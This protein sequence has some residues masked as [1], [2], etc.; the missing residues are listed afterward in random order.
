M[1]GVKAV[2]ALPP[3]PSASPAPT[4]F[5]TD[6]QALRAI[7]VLLV[8][9][10][11]VWPATV[12]G[13]Y[14]GVDVFFVIS[15]YLIT[16]HLV[17]EVAATGRLD[18]PAF[19]ARR[20]RRLLPAASL[21]LVAVGLATYMWVPPATWPI[22][23][24][25]MVASTLYAENWALVRRAVDYLA[26]D[27]TPSPLQH[28]WSLAVEEQFYVG[29][30]LLVAG[31]AAAW[32]RRAGAMADPLFGLAPPPPPL[33][34]FALP[35]GVLCGL[36]FV[37]AQ[38]YAHANPAA[39]YF[40][41]HT[42][43]HELG[44]GGLLGV[45]AAARAPAGPH[46]NAKLGKPTARPAS[47]WRRTFAAA[48]GL[49]AVGASGCLYTAATP[50]PGTAALVPVLGAAAVIAAGEG[51]V[52]N[53]SPAHALA[54]ALAHPWLQYV[55][56]ISYSLYL[57][58][59]PVVVMYPFITGRAV[60]GVFADGVTVLAL[61]WAMAHACKRGWED[62]FRG[63]GG[64]GGGGGGACK[65]LARTG[66]LRGAISMTVGMAL[67]V[68]A[69]S[70]GLRGR[71]MQ[72]LEAPPGVDAALSLTET[73]PSMPPDSSSAP[74]PRT[75]DVTRLQGDA[76]DACSF[77]MGSRDNSDPSMHFPGADIAV[78]GCPLTNSLPISKARPPVGVASED[79]PWVFKKSSC[80]IRHQEDAELTPCQAEQPADASTPSRR[81]HVVLI[82]DSHAAHWVPAFEA[83]S[84]RMGFRF[85]SLV[86]AGC[87]PSAGL[88]AGKSA[89]NLVCQEWVGKAV[90]WV[91]RERPSAVVLSSH[92]YRPASTDP[93]NAAE[94]AEGVVRIARQ[95]VAAEIP[96]LG[97]KATPSMKASVPQC[98]AMA[99]ARDPGTRDVAAC[100]M[101]Q[102]A[103]LPHPN[104]PV[105]A[106]AEM[107]PIMRLLSFD[108][109][110]CDDQ[111]C[112]AMMGNVIVYR[113]R[114][115]LT[116]TFSA[117]LATALQK[118]LEAAA[119]HLAE[120]RP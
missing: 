89:P 83:A 19:Y 45:W 87:P 13:G 61:S 98:L 74:I 62:R 96:V 102:A 26:Q 37:T 55:G 71:A 80:A 94:L 34:A 111:T 110:L 81:P 69:V 3:F 22:T 109:V 46:G 86:K 15:G 85:T 104:N 27:Q 57:A 97:I 64:G 44:L 90:D 9:A 29:W 116:A 92:D 75:G 108:E 16:G 91:L 38:Y 65:S 120:S 11:H 33:R 8:I 112:P 103:A 56:D 67:V 93:S 84:H 12:R 21:T 107:Y 23:A 7:A 47:R 31:A 79:A 72:H 100:S 35:M 43:L 6:I 14:V 49:A 48:A 18:L 73:L 119:P 5:R 99:E 88:A 60:D 1:P 36:S 77:L 105:N 76:R 10:F 70:F 32:T 4:R 2:A 68:A 115:H 113:D 25:D 66:E 41:T 30:P 17:R 58:H 95:V 82:G 52:D 53:E 40:M 101:P 118:K 106:A 50:F 28:F 117:T 20:A 59:W 54:P 24:A 42:R 51:S 63:G 114:H 78:H 39:G